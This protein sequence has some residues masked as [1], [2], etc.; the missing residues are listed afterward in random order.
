MSTDV[1][2]EHQQLLAL[3]YCSRLFAVDPEQDLDQHKHELSK[4][5][6]DKHFCRCLLAV[7]F[8]FGEGIPRIVTLMP[9]L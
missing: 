3:L 6:Q 9:F 4:P 1:A 5:D 2:A 8:I 7:R